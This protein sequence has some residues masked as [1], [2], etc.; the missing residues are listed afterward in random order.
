MCL[1]D[2]V[3]Q[4]LGPASGSA[5]AIHCDDL[6]LTVAGSEQLTLVSCVCPNSVSMDAAGFANQVEQAYLAIKQ[7]LETRSVAAVYP[8]RF[9][10]FI[11]QIHEPMGGGLDRYMVFNSGR[12][13]AF[14]HWLA[15]DPRKE[16][17]LP[18]A[19]GV[20]HNGRDLVIHCLASQSPGQAVENP[21]QRPAYKYSQRFG[22]LPPC[23]AR[24]TVV[25]GV[26][27]DDPIILIGGTASVLGEDSLHIDDAESQTSETIENLSSLICQACSGSSAGSNGHDHAWLEHLTHLRV[28]YK[29]ES[30]KGQIESLIAG[31][32]SNVGQIEIHQAEL[33]RQ[34]LLVEIE[35]T[36]RKMSAQ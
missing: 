10:N 33:C 16:Q 28:Y 9:W 7:Q 19:T 32:I 20:G 24:A 6:I 11:P 15:P 23:F 3:D 5:Q 17:L 34:D 30:D 35:G 2:W 29:N 26:L 12:F 8:I 31:R 18:T 21:R 14:S 25:E 22:P 1:P 4:C 27:G 36:A 13:E